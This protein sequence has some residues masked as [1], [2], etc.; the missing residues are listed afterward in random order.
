MNLLQEIL[1]GD[2]WLV[3]AHAPDAHA[4]IEELRASCLKEGAAAYI[5][6]LDKGLVSV[7]EC[8][9]SV[10]GTAR[11]SDAMRYVKQS[12]HYGIY[13]FPQIPSQYFRELTQL[14][15]FLNRK[16]GQER[17]VVLVGDDLEI[18]VGIEAE[19]T[20]LTVYNKEQLRPRLRDGKW[21][22]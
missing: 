12:P 9:F 22:I 2:S 21:I 7:R 14:A 11:I 16:R 6:Y 15:H 5:W 10:P 13:V 4:T 18:P 19:I 3:A 20:H 8:D 1:K 17:R